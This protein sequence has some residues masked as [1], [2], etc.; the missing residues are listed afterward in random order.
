MADMLRFAHSHGIY[1]VNFKKFNLA[2]VT[3]IGSEQYNF[4]LS[5]KFLNEK[6]K[7]N[8][9]VIKY[10]DIETTCWETNPDKGFGNCPFPWTHYLLEWRNPPM[11]CK[12]FPKE[13][14][15]AMVLKNL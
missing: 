6:Q 4:F 3:G 12:A 15:S 2:A 14:D 11:L 13:L 9:A 7:L 8:Q 10:P 5:E 1:N